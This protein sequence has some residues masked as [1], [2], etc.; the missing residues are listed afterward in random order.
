MMTS[1]EINVSCFGKELIILLFKYVVRKMF[2]DVFSFPPCV[3]LEA[4]SLIAATP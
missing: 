3:H 2:Y 4:L 1:C